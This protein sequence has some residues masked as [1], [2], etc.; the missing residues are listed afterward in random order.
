VNRHGILGTVTKV[1][2]G[3]IRRACE[4]FTVER[5]L[6]LAPS[7]SELV[8]ILRAHRTVACFGESSNG[9]AGSKATPQPWGGSRG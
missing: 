5:L 2:V 6:L 8:R 9:L 1:D 7:R 3:V 4:A